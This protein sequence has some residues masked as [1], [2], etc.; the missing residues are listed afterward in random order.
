MADILISH[1]NHLYYDR[2]QVRKMQPYPPLQA[3]LAAASLR[4]AGHDVAL[5]D[6]T[7]EAPE[8]GFRAALARHR[9]RRVF[10][11]EDN[12]NFLTK[13]CLTRNR[14]LAFHMA[15]L[16][17]ELGIPVAVAGSDAADRAGDYLSHG[18]AAVIQGEVE[19]A[20]CEWAGS[21]AQ[22]VLRGVPRRDLNSL[23]SPAWDLIDVEAYR[24]AWIRA[25]GFFSLN[26]VASR[27]CPFRCNW[28]AKPVYGDTYR[29]A[30]AQR[31][32][33]ELAGVK[34]AYA[35]D[36]IWFADDIFA[37]TAS[38]T[39]AFAQA[40]ES[41]HAR[42]SFKMQSRCDLMTRSTVS[43]LRRAG[44]AEV[45]L[46]AESGSQ[47]VLDAM[48]KGIRVDQ[49]HQA[50]ENLHA[51]GIRA[52]LFL[53]FGYPGETWD[54]IRRTIDMVRQVKPDD[55]GISVAYPLPG[56]RF[57]DA[58]KSQFGAKTNWDD[59]DDLSMMFQGA[60]RSEFYRALRDALHLELSGGDG[61]AEA[62]RQVEFLEKTAAAENPTVLWS[63]C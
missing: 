18:A 44:C 37:L 29:T 15:G 39:E 23:P 45:W 36:Q 21:N 43:A 55:A 57:H 54:D 42:V 34:A 14:E 53:Q 50:C 19:S 8:E 26:L 7:L 46:G 10:L 11:C 9:P 51:H 13:M 62:W 58:V 40:V 22:G 27:G 5:F 32:A 6:A 2:K 63:Y 30:S 20:I 24:A 56:T 17:S 38:W 33:G 16:A 31:V 52:C 60:Y 12:F 4:E 41:R 61:Q 49:I 28:C 47:R 35:P 59:S 3:I 25:H 1:C 48:D